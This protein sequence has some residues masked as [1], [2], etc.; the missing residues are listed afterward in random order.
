MAMELVSFKCPW[1]GAA[2]DIE[3]ESELAV[4]PYCR[5]EFLVCEGED[6]TENETEVTR[7]KQAETDRMVRLKQL[8][9]IEKRRAEKQ[10]AKEAKAKMAKKAIIIGIPMTVIGFLLGGMSG[11]GDSPLYF[12]AGFGFLAVLFGFTEL[13]APQKD[14]DDDL[15]FGD[16]VRIPES[17]YEYPSK[18]YGV[19]QGIL[20]SAG[21]TNIRCVPLNDLSFLRLKTPGTVKSVT[22]NG[23]DAEEAVSRKKKYPKDAVI[24]ISYHSLSE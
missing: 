18:D 7:L 6:S 4:C 9:M 2:L 20:L 16:K 14:N 24:V 8:E 10:K 22:V 3:A 12:V 13:F 21:F 17:I 11:D 19:V 1:C 23:E 5:T 15:D